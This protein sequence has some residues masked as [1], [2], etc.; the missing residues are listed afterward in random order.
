MMLMSIQNRISITLSPR[1]RK[2]LE[3]AAG[4]EGSTTASHASQLLSYAIKNEIK[5]DPILF[6]KWIE[7][8]K[9]ALKNESWDDVATPT[10][11]NPE[12][13]SDSTFIQKGWFLAGDNPDGYE[14][15]K[16]KTI[17]Y[18]GTE[19]G[20]IK[21]KRNNVKGF[22][23]LMQQTDVTSYVG[24]KLRYSAVIKAD[25]VKN[26]AGLWV[27][28]DDND[29]QYLWFDNMQ[30]RPI[31]GTLGWKE[32]NITFNVPNQSSTLNFGVLLVGS[33]S[34]WINKVSVV[35]L[36]KKMEKSATDLGLS[37]IF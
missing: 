22:G 34:V 21:S 36:S 14:V 4:L 18:K 11:I 2:A 33:G 7:L 15:G 31:K 17:T 19:G 30:D 16:D 13:M 6:Q 20:F 24:K 9:E 28:L 12:D 37:L 29:M 35:E 10:T 8:E 32:F 1:M 27:R 26:W 3:L 25:K 23:T 5:D